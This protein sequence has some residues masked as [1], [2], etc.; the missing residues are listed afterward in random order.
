MKIGILGGT[1][2]PIHLAHLR[3]AEEA[4]DHLQLDK[5]LF[6]P[7]ATP[8]HKQLA[9]ELAF[10]HRLQ[11]THLAV[12]DNPFFS[13]SDLEGKRGGVSYLIDTLRQLREL[14]PKDR[15]FFIMGSDSFAEI[16]SWRDYREFFAICSM[17][18]VQRPPLHNLDP[19]QS[20]PVDLAGDFCYHVAD[21]RFIHSSG[22]IIDFISGALLDISSSTV[23][24]LIRNGKSVRY[25]IPEPVEHYIRKHGLYANNS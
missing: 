7:T 16:S 3:I 17:I 1:F 22:E 21:R 4:R 11:M 20:L 8:P 2:N 23:R 12:A 25:L 14:F 5:V 13:V 6:I 19:E 9:G 15:L 18:V 10:E 24:D